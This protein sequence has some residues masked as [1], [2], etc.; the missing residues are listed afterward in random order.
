MIGIPTQELEDKMMRYKLPSFSLTAALLSVLLLSA[1]QPEKTYVHLN[2]FT[3]GTTYQVTIEKK[4]VDEIALQAEIDKRLEKINQLMSTYIDDSELSRFNRKLSTD[5][6]KLS[7]ETIYVIQHAINVSQETQ[8]KFD[9]TLA[10]LIEIW[11]FDKKDT[12]NQIPTQIK[13]DSI[14][15]EFGYQNIDIQ[16]GCIAKKIP[17]LSINLSAIAKGYGV[18]EIAKLIRSKGITNYLVEIGGELASKGINAKGRPW[19]I[20]IESA[21]SQ[22]RSIQRVLAPKGLGVATSGDYR[23]YFEKDGKRFS[24]TIDPTTG[25]PINHSLASITVLHKQTMRADALA[26]AMMVMGPEAALK[27][28]NKKQL[29]VFMLVKSEQGFK[30]VYSTAFKPF[31]Q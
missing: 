20:A 14:L 4:S 9:V 1:C 28:A 23:N 6:Q 10:P 21:S 18:D 27:Y 5:C 12:H 26:T 25:Y 15:K 22:K 11:G 3:M 8:G 29:P 17:Q 2:G 24:H 16:S 30:E 13:I 31:L 19:Q 7:P